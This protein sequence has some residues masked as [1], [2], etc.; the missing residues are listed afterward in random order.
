M[1]GG[2]PTAIQKAQLYAHNC[3]VTLFPKKKS[4][5]AQPISSYHVFFAN[6]INFIEERKNFNVTLIRNM[7]LECIKNQVHELMY[8]H[9]IKT[10]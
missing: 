2:G 10:F 8:C 5:T 1:V 6:N 9:E 7:K 4:C 3:G